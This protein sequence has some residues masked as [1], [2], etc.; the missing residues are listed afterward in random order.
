M[1]SF[2]PWGKKSGAHVF[3]APNDPVWRSAKHCMGEKRSRSE[4][5][6]CVRPIGGRE[7][8]R[9]KLDHSTSAG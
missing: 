7:A 3:R 4:G 5:A 1:R 8:P 9:R 2:A 6:G